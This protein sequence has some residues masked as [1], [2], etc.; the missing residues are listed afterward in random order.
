[1]TKRLENKVALIT[2]GSRGIGKA[3]AIAF[4]EAGAKLLLNARNEETL[5]TTAEELRE[6]GTQIEYYACDVSDRAA[7]EKMIAYAHDTFGHIDIL[8]NNAGVY[9]PARFVDYSFEDF[10]NVVSVNLYS[11]FHMAQAVLPGMMERKQGRIINV[12]STAGKWG[13]RNQSAYNAS[14]HAV[15]GLTRCLGLEMAPYNINVNAICPWFVETD[16]V[17]AALS[18]HAK[19]AGVPVEAVEKMLLSSG[20]KGRFIQP[21]EVA[22]LAVYLA[23]DESSY[24]NCQAIVIDGG[25]TMT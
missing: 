15:V 19:I 2:G 10:S 6:H 23:S 18:E 20:P 14:K 22:H 11:V 24:I 21:E 25:Y 17:P 4:A 7:I 1:M 5:A 16:M 8:V 12:A 9:K 13:S 3:I